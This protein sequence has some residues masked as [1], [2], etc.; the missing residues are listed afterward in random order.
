MK[1][2][3]YFLSA[4]LIASSLL[5]FAACSDDSSGGNTAGAGGSDAGTGGTAGSGVSGKGGSGGSKA[6]TGGTSAGTGGTSAGTDG[7]AGTGGTDPFGPGGGGEAGTGDAGTGGTGDAGT[8]GTAGTGNG[9][10]NPGGPCQDQ[11]CID[12]CVEDN[13]GG[14]DDFNAFYGCIGSKCPTECSPSSGSQAACS[15]CQEAKCSAEIGAC[16]QNADCGAIVGCINGQGAGGAG[17]SGGGVTCDQVQLSSKAACNTCAQ[18]TCCDQ[19]EACV[20]DAGCVAL[21]N[22]VAKCASNDQACQQACAGANPDA[23]PTLNALGE[24]V[25][26]EC[27]TECQ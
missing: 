19:I 22:C 15:T 13:S 6:G 20:N 25:Q 16:Q 26:G 2:T 18:S 7:D 5:A 9:G 14:A 1:A 23:V 11:A 4:G 12:Q 10:S 3:A 21:N 8:G 24:C 27:A 17:G